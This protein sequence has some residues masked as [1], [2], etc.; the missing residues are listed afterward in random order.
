[1]RYRN[2]SIYDG[3]W[4]NGVKHGDGC[5]ITAKGEKKYGLFQNNKIVKS[6]SKTVANNDD[7]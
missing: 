5:F 3:H 6:L 4:S 1:M 2:G 7:T